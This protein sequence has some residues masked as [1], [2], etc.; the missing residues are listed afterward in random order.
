MKFSGK[1]CLKIM[2][3]V[4]KNRGF[5]LSLEDTLFEKPRGGGGAIYRPGI[6]GVNSLI[7]ID[8]F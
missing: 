6:L 5:T 8:L 4:T 3:K 1:I 2:L 7:L